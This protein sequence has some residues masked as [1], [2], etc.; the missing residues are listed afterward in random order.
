MPHIA[1]HQSTPSIT[2]TT[3]HQRHQN[4]RIKNHIN[5]QKKKKK[6]HLNPP[7]AES[8]IKIT[9]P[10]PSITQNWHYNNA[11]N[12]A[13]R[14]STYWQQQ[15]KHH[16]NPWKSTNTHNNKTTG[17]KRKPSENKRKEMSHTV[18]DWRPSRVDG[19]ASSVAWWSKWWD[20][21][22]C[23]RGI[24]KARER[25]RDLC[26]EEREKVNKIRIKVLA[27]FVHTISYLEVHCSLMLKVL[28]FEKPDE[29]W[30]LVLGVPNI[31]H[32]AHLMVML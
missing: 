7:T 5:T 30:F 19:M 29:G 8:T 13:R 2:P 17:K 11:N 21:R 24:E 32:L 6:T 22:S 31:W 16:H 26:W 12:K 20:R 18:R 9:P 23:E 25:E 10:Q 1:P 14:K 3:H 15:Q 28:R 4:H 27:F